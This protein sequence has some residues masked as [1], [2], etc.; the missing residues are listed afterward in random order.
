MVHSAAIPLRF[1]EHATISQVLLEHN[2]N[3]TPLNTPAIIDGPSGQVAYT[4]QSFRVAVR[5]LAALLHAEVGLRHGNTVCLLAL[6]SVSDPPH[7]HRKE[8]P[9]PSQL[10][11]VCFAEWKAHDYPRST[12]PCTYMPCWHAVLRFLRLILLTEA[13]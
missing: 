6:N 12:T 1:P 11:V 10:R 5:K 3:N 2:I 9:R 7:I 4:Y 8:R 13:M